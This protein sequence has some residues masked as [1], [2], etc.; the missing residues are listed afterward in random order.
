[1]SSGTYQVFAASNWRVAAWPCLVPFRA[2]VCAPANLWWEQ[3][4]VQ[5]EIQIK[6]PFTLTEEEQERILVEAADLSV[7][8]SR[9]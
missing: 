5:Y 3:N 2:E 1:M 8:A 6:L 9:E 7:A 4:G